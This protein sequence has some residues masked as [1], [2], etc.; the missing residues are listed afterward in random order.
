MLQ[1]F[2]E[3][4]LTDGKGVTVDCRDAIFIMTSNLAQ[5]EIAEE[6]APLRDFIAQHGHEAGLNDE[7]TSALKRFL[8]ARVFPILRQH[9]RRDEFL[10]RINEVLLFLP[11]TDQ[12]LQRIVEKELE[13]WAGRA[14]TRHQ[15]TMRWSPEVVR[16]LSGGYNIRYGA[17][18]IKHEVEKRVVNQLAKAHELDHIQAGSVIDVYVD[19]AEI[20]LRFSEP[21]DG[22]K[23]SAAGGG[24]LSTLFGGGGGSSNDAAKVPT[25]AA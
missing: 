7:S 17:R 3:G 13:Y 8:N 18:S 25:S 5:E 1:V 24:L 23:K 2:D 16:V 4:R 14:Q 9:F 20:R 22:S 19:G 21:S 10:G 11:F 6:S 15:M 12:E